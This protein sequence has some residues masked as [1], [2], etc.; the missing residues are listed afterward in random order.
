M[1]HLVIIFAAIMCSSGAAHAQHEDPATQADAQIVQEVLGSTTADVLTPQEAFDAIIDFGLSDRE[2]D[3][4][5]AFSRSAEGNTTLLRQLGTNNE[6]IIDQMGARNL[7]VLLQQGNGNA[8]SARQS[9]TG[10]IIGVRLLGSDN[11]L[12]VH[13]SGLDNMYLL[14][15]TG[16]GLN[17][18]P[19]VQIGTGNQAVQL[20]LTAAPFGVEQYGNGMRMIIRHNEAK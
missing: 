8:T 3:A 16:N 10:N 4:L 9:G 5:G 17:I 2:S 19:A 13:Q 1:R 15:F 14:D 11:Q 6:A 12:E 18:A 7:A 20:G